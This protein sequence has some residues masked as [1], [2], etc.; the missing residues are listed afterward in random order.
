M[1]NGKKQASEVPSHLHLPVN[2][3]HPRMNFFFPIPYPL[4]ND[5]VR[6]LFHRQKS[7]TCTT[8]PL[9]ITDVHRR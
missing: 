7:H 2:L 8:S 9:K 6:F 4:T 1:K 5:H 3:R